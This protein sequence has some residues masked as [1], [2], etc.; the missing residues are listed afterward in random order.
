M[1]SALLLM[2]L[3]GAQPAHAWYHTFQVWDEGDLP[4][5]WTYYAP[6]DGTNLISSMDDEV[7]LDIVDQSF[8]LW[9]EDMPCAGLGASLSRTPSTE[10][11]P[12]WA[13]DAN[14]ISFNNPD[15]DDGTL[16]YTRCEPGRTAYIK[17][18]NS[19]QFI[20]ECDI[21]FNGNYSWISNEDID[22]GRCTGQTSLDAVATHEIGHLW[23]MAHSCDDPSDDA[24]QYKPANVSCDTPVSDGTT[25]QDAIMFWSVGP[26]DK[27]PEGGF[28]ADDVE[29]LY[30]LYGP[31]CAIRDVST[32]FRGGTNP[33]DPFEVCFELA[34][35]EAEEPPHTVVWNFGD[36]TTSE[37]YEDLTR[38]ID[39][40]EVEFTGACHTYTDK[41]QFS[42]SV[43]ID[44]SSETC[45]DWSTDDIQTAKVTVCDA[46]E[47]AEGFN[48]LFTWEHVDG[49]VYQMVNQV[50]TSVYGCVDSIIWEVYSGG[51]VSGEP[52]QQVGSWAPKI[53]FGSEGTYTV[54][55]NVGG[56][57]GV[58]AAQ[59]TIDAV[60]QKGEGQ[61]CSAAGG[62]ASLLGVFVGLGAA[63][64]RRRD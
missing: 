18:G 47:V 17:D 37:Q 42:I 30:A 58:N 38:E 32:E 36:G 21:T 12:T 9:V 59:L 1:T 61:G 29:G 25:L 2:G 63:L 64:R 4:I 22:G 14:V 54:V 56:P 51:S 45:G 55:L 10:A 24:D 35:S 23:G 19:Y 46:P 50:D 44:G 49:L 16:A 40:E 15:V 28:T 34:C 41:G 57:G 39:G 7:V 5:T 62:A 3:L 11:V 31:S 27:G 26:C 20:E 13:D 53:E 43:E 33:D 8:N 6:T 48:G 60:D 52:I